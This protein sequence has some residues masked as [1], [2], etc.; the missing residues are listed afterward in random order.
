MIR[1]GIVN[2]LA[3]AVEAMRRIILNVPGYEVAWVARNGVEAVEKCASDTPHLVLMDIIMPVMDGVEATRRIM[4]ESPCPIL[5]VSAGPDDKVSKVF[6]AM[7]Y[8]AL[9][10]VD[11]PSMGNDAAAQRNR[12]VLLRKIRILSRLAGQFPRAGGNRAVKP[13]PPP[14]VKKARPLIGIGAS[15][16][17]PKALLE[18]LSSIPR[19]ISAPIVIVQHV[20]EAFSAGMTSWLNRQTEVDVVLAENGRRPEPGKAYVASTNDHLVLSS[21]LT[22]GYTQEPRNATYRPSIDTFFTSVAEYWPGKGGAALLTGM[23]K[24]GAQGLALLRQKGWYTIAQDEAT[25]IVYGMP[26]AA[27]ELGAAVDI[28]P[29]QDIGKAIMDFLKR[30]SQGG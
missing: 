23:G 16:G 19:S 26:K 1:I 22:F 14:V 10:V 28:L 15:T 2:D 20:D 9:D 8:G 24:D 3:L 27:K 17:G 29:V 13:P 6:E 30:S 12:E 11:T 5:I 25:S 21:D 18:V 4:K 7:G